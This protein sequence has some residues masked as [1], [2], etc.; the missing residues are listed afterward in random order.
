MPPGVHKALVVTVQSGHTML[1]TATALD[2]DF[3]SDANYSLHSSQPTRCGNSSSS[4]S[5]GDRHITTESN[6][7]VSQLTLQTCPCR[8]DTPMEPVDRKDAQ[9]GKRGPYASGLDRWPQ[10]LKSLA[11]ERHPRRYPGWLNIPMKTI[12]GQPARGVLGPWGA[13]N[14]ATEALEAEL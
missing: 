12:N 3:N 7:L 6:G 10:H 9:R 13:V 14:D 11:I 2:H 1:I 8:D 4:G 5:I